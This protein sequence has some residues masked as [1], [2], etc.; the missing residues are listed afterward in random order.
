M[1]LGNSVIIRLCMEWLSANDSVALVSL[2]CS[3][4][5]PLLSNVGGFFNFLLYNNNAFI[6]ILL[7]HTTTTLRQLL[8]HTP[9]TAG[10]LWRVALLFS[11]FILAQCGNNTQLSILLLSFAKHYDYYCYYRCCCYERNFLPHNIDIYRMFM[12]VNT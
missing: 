9:N 2:R 5:F 11:I 6:Y 10:S 3:T 12:Y 1:Q 4:N 7:T 8:F